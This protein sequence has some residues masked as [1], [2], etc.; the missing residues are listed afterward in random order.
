MLPHPND[1]PTGLRESPVGVTVTPSVRLNLLSPELCVVH[2]PGRMVGTPVPK[3][4]VDHHYNSGSPKDEI[5][6]STEPLKDLTVYQVAEAT[7]VQD[8]AQ[9]E[10]G[11]RIARIRPA[12]PVADRSR[13]RL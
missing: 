6:S 12:H 13:R 10:L 1:F 2:R 3:A 5:G 4:P 7:P 9:F 8:P 11:L